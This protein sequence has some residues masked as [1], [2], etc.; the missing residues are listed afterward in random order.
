MIACLTAF[1]FGHKRFVWW[2]NIAKLTLQT[3][4]EICNCHYKQTKYSA[5][6]DEKCCYRQS[7]DI[8]KLKCM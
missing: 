6:T 5:G 7:D 2:L 4:K 1:L 8:A 3:V